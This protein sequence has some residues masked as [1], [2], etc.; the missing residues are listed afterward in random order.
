MPALD[1]PVS[2]HIPDETAW[3]DMDAPIDTIPEDFFRDRYVGAGSAWINQTYVRLRLAGVEVMRSPQILPDV[4]NVTILDYSRFP[5]WSPDRFVVVV[6]PDRSLPVLGQFRIE[7]V[8]L[9]E[10]TRR[11]AA[12]PHWPQSGIIPRRPERGA[13]I[14]TLCYRGEIFNLDERF[15]SQTFIDDLSAVGVKLDLPPDK[16]GW[17]GSSDMNWEDYRDAD[18]VVAARNLPSYFASLKPASKLVNAWIAEVP[19]LLGP[20]RPFL[21]LRQS[22][23]D[24]IE[25]TQPEHVL[26]AITDLRANPQ[27][28]LGM[29]ENGR[30][31]RERF[32][33]QRVTEDWVRTLNG[34]VKDAFLRWQRT[35]APY[36]WTRWSACQVGERVMRNVHRVRTRVGPRILE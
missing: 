6:R 33:F 11:R 35:S 4:V 27:K 28:Y 10:V 12:V 14:E 2:F 32:T 20:E 1:I 23:L 21:E 34:P 13:R 31:R 26:A 8:G 19:A 18:L 15:R 16:L 25:V 24:F 36:R 7:Q 5:Y 29:V 30:R 17:T 22:A 9:S 3:A